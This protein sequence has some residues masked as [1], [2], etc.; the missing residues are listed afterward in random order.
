MPHLREVIN[1][2]QVGITKERAREEQTKATMEKYSD[3]PFLL[4]HSKIQDLRRITNR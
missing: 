1:H 3:Y 4:W 2:L